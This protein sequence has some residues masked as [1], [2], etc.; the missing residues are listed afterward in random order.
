MLKNFKYYE[1]DVNDILPI[2]WVE[3]IK[4]VVSKYAKLVILT[5]QS[6]TSRELKNDLKIETLVVDGEVIKEKL[7]WLYKLYNGYFKELGQKCV[8]ESLVT[9][10]NTLYAVNLNIQKGSRMRYECHVD[11]NPLQGVLYVTTHKE[12]TGGELIVSNNIDALGEEEIEKN[13]EKIFPNCGY[14]VF[15]D[16][17]KYPHFVKSLINENDERI[18]VTMNFY[19]Q[20]DP[21]DSRPED[22]NSHL[23][24][25]KV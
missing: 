5:S 21:E 12:G 22:L 9:A 16:A 3:E 1:Y 20:S 19:T 8:S 2:H 18:S 11:S 15:F 25:E 24:G 6:V 4:G 17:R 23:F 10:K 14:I 13:S 7:P